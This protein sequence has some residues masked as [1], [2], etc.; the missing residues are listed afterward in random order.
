MLCSILAAIM[1]V[2]MA[3]TNN[4]QY[5]IAAALF[6]IAGVL[7]TMLRPRRLTPKEDK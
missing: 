3:V 7:H 6:E 2:A 1:L 5:A 4:A